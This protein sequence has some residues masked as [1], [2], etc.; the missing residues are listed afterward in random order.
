MHRNLHDWWEG[1]FGRSATSQDLIACFRQL[2]MMYKAGIPVARSFRI[3]SNQVASRRLKDTFKEVQKRLEAGNSI[4]TSLSEFSDIFPRLYVKLITVGESTGKL[5]MVLDSIADHAEKAHSRE[6]KLRTAITYPAFVLAVCLVF[7]IVGPAFFL[8]GICDFLTSLTIPLPF[9]TRFLIEVSSFMRS[10]FF[11]F[12]ILILLLLG[13]TFIRRMWNDTYSRRYLQDFLLAI[14]GI[15][16]FYRVTQLIYYVKALAIVC[17]SGMP[18]VE[19]LEL[20]KQSINLVRMESELSLVT[21]RVVEGVSLKEA[22]ELSGFFPPMILQFIAAGEES[23]QLVKMLNW[24]AW[25]CEQNNE[26]ALNIIMETIQPFVM[27]IIGIIIGFLII[28][29]MS[30]MMGVIRQ[31][32]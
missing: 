16:R 24:S 27:L 30:P 2:A 32:S 6:L 25:I 8:K 20:A 14:P 21:E 15:G 1:Y 3:L 23:G 31:I 19:G 12:S 26:T 22:F 7:L 4:S 11:M 18:L 10:P 9:T 17:E 29:T 5:A 28:A 13:Y